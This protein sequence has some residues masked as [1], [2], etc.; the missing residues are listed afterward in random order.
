MSLEIILAVFVPP[1]AST[2]KLATDKDNVG[3]APF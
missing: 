1:D 3:L 2:V